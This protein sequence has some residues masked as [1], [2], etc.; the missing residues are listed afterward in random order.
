LVPGRTGFTEPPTH[1]IVFLSV[2]DGAVAGVATTIARLKP[3]RAVSFVH[4]SGALGLDVLDALRGRHLI[5]SF[6]PLQSFPAP[7]G[8][9]AFRRITIAI[10]ASTPSLNRRLGSIATEIG[11]HPIHVPDSDRVVYHAAAVFASNLLNVVV[12]QAV[13]L[14]EGIGWSEHDA[15]SALMPLIEGA[16]ANIRKRGPVGALTGPIRRGDVEIVTR[17][18]AALEELDRSRPSRPGAKLAVVYRMLG[19]IAL[20][21]AKEAGLQPAAAELTQRA[22]TPKR[23]A[24]QGR[25]R[26]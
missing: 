3:P 23:A 6:H 2:P 13:Q 21:I 18:L 22:L 11:A 15:T 1:G 17:H 20:E 14:L 26:V 24:T 10:D 8:P 7:R 12:A 5:G 25:R 16:V 9:A 19:T 4:V